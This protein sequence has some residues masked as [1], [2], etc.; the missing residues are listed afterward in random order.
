MIKADERDIDRAG[1]LVFRRAFEQLN[2]I[3]DSIEDAISRVD[4]LIY[5]ALG[6]QTSSNTI[7]HCTLY[8]L[9]YEGI[10]AEEAFSSLKS[11][12]WDHCQSRMPRPA[13]WTFSME[14]RAR[15]GAMYSSFVE[16]A[17]RNGH[18]IRY[19]TTDDLD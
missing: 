16:A 2:W 12:S 3:P 10:S 14:E 15:I 8:D 17:S 9:H 6:I 19:R 1:R 11:N 7:A 13:E 4:R 18:G 5:Y